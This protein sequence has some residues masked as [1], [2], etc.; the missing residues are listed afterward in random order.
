VLERSLTFLERSHSHE[1]NDDEVRSDPL[2]DI[3]KTMKMIIY[4]L[5]PNMIYCVRFLKGK[6]SSIGLHCL[7]C[8]AYVYFFSLD[9]SPTSDYQ[10]IFWNVNTYHYYWCTHLCPWSSLCKG[11]MPALAAGNARAGCA[12]VWLDDSSAQEMSPQLDR[13]DPPPSLIWFQTD[14][15]D[16]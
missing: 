4:I 11:P 6:T 7:I 16:A 3:S 14:K 15:M 1:N 9:Q 10:Q 8:W 13:L 2:Q 12:G 5:Y